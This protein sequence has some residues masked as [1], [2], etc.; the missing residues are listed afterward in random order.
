[1]SNTFNVTDYHRETDLE[2][3]FTINDADGDPL[4]LAE[5][6]AMWRLS[7]RA[8]G[9]ALITK[10]IGAGIA[11]TEEEAGVLVVT[12]NRAETR[13]MLG[14]YHHELRVRL[15]DAEDVV[16]NGQFVVRASPPLPLE[17]TSP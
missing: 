9:P 1:M 17:E 6:I 14:A 15:N 16:I 13:G 7:R 10:T 3:E 12:V 2:I 11:V 8:T 5:A 4:N